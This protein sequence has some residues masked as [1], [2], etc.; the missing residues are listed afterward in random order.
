[1]NRRSSKQAI[2]ALIILLVFSM[3]AEGFPLL[4]TENH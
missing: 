2:W 4:S 3:A 1:M